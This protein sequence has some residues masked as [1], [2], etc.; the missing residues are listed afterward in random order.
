MVF[1]CTT[2]NHNNIEVKQKTFEELFTSLDFSNDQTYL[3][4]YPT[5]STMAQYTNT[6]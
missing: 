3:P 4:R 6:K 1:S 5:L 2:S